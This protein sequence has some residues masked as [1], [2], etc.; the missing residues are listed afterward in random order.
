MGKNAK[1]PKKKSHI[2]A[3]AV[4]LSILIALL[5]LG[6][7]YYRQ[8]QYYLDH[9]YP[10][11]VLNGVDCSELTVPEA[12]SI[13]QNFIDRYTFTLT[14][15]EGRS[16]TIT[17]QQLEMTYESD[18][19]VAALLAAQEPALWV[20]NMNHPESA[21]AKLDYTF[22]TEA[23]DEWLASLPCVTDGT[24]PEDAYIA[25]YEDGYWH[26]IPE[27]EGNLVDLEKAKACV[28]SAIESGA[29]TL[30]LAEED[31][32][33][34]P[35][36]RSDEPSL[37]EE[38]KKKNDEL[39]RQK[40]IEEI[41]DVSVSLVILD[42]N[43]ETP[44]VLDQKALKEM[45]TD[46]PD[47]EPQIDRKKL[48]E[49]VRKWA[50]QAGILED[51]H[52]FLN[53][54]G[55]LLHLENGTD[56]GWQLDLEKTTDAVLDAVTKKENKTVKAVL[57]RAETG[58]LQ[59]EE[60]YVEI[61]IHEQRMLCYQN[62]ELKVDT[63]VVTG[64]VVTDLSYDTQTPS[65][66]IWHIF[67]KSQNYHMKGPRQSDGSYEYE[68]DVEFWMPFNG[69]IGIHDKQ[70]RPAFGGDIYIAGGSHGCI[71]TPYEAAKQIYEITSVG[72]PVIVWG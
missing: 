53:C 6:L 70:D 27:K 16:E 13:L 50:E 34:K 4:F 39:D 40:R 43:T 49:W 38:A 25:P 30:S 56:A 62:G 14:D 44:S 36:V 31:C 68:T 2:G 12:E 17:A 18:G 59:S 23:A 35:A 64:A 46:E 58:T 47:A 21:K 48:T 42:E 51:N 11:T 10:G 19:T 41:T 65:D 52:L 5:F 60:T 69:D 54:Y 63:P 1:S 28:R 61:I 32:Y 29:E 33:V 45:I 67:W 72:T 7:L 8:Y 26:V 37:K 66:G 22:R 55:Q 20:F 71:N 9:F 57:T 3:V 24:P 15:A